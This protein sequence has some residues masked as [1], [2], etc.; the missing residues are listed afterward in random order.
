MSNIAEI[1]EPQAKTRSEFIDECKSGK[2]DSVHAIYRTF[3]SV[4]ITGRFDPELVAVL[5]KNLK[6]LAHV[7]A[8]YD[9]VDV[10]ACS[11]RDPPIRV[12]NTP[13]AVDNATADTAVFLMLGALRGFNVGMTSLRQNKW[14]GEPALPLGHDPQGKVLGILGM[15]GIGRNMMKKCTAFGMKT[16]YHNRNRLDDDKSGGA[17]YV[18][19]DELLAQS[20][21]LSLNL[22]LNVSEAQ[23][24]QHHLRSRY[25]S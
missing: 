5:P 23:C 4:E 24:M 15:G 21:V 22:P 12:S 16:I 6:Y 17:Q 7:G 8:G 11:E 1:I 20:D 3:A 25:I 9:Q 19:F 14:R 18:S 13:T 10:K 2:L